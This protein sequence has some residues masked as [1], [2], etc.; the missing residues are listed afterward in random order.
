MKKLFQGKKRV[1]SIPTVIVIGLVISFII[2]SFLENS[3]KSLGLWKW[4]EKLT[5]NEYIVLIIIALG[6]VGVFYVAYLVIEIISLENEY[7]SKS[8]EVEKSFEEKSR[9]QAA[10]ILDKNANLRKVELQKSI[11]T[12]MENF[13]Q[14]NNAIHAAQLYKYE[15]TSYQINMEYKVTYYDGYVSEGIDINGI[16]QQYYSINKNDYQKYKD[17]IE[18]FRT[19]NND[20]KLMD[21]IEEKI[22]YF[23]NASRLNRNEDGLIY[24][25]LLDAYATL[26]TVSEDLESIDFPKSK[27]DK[28]EKL[29]GKYKRLS[30]FRGILIN[31]FYMSEYEGNGD[32]QGRIYA[33]TPIKIFNSTMLLLIAIDGEL[34]EDANKIEDCLDEL[35]QSIVKLN[36]NLE[37]ENSSL[38]LISKIE[39]V[40]HEFTLENHID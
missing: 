2:D 16:L 22:N 11:R 36:R 9:V 13:V 33:T 7:K 8:E 39:N 19:G 27:K 5:A 20:D 40:L 14:N 37:S 32:K 10:I 31:G 17:G 34:L 6:I 4:I 3:D 28:L 35:V 24:A 38:S 23:N 26:S 29:K 25:T 30:I 21:Y 1:V 12:V 15:T 18:K